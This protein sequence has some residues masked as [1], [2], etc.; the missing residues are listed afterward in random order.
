MTI[1]LPPKYSADIWSLF[2]LRQVR[3]HWGINNSYIQLR[4]CVCVCERKMCATNTALARDCF[5][6]PTSIYL[7]P[8]KG[9]IERSG[10]LKSTKLNTKIR[11][12]NWNQYMN[13]IYTYI[14]CCG[15]GWQYCENDSTLFFYIYIYILYIWQKKRRGELEQAKCFVWAT[16]VATW[17]CQEVY[18]LVAWIC[19]MASLKANS[20]KIDFSRAVPVPYLVIHTDT[21]PP[22]QPLPL[23]LSPSAPKCRQ[24]ATS[25]NPTHET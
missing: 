15:A 16:G 9:E 8:K 7:K 12:S 3:R 2:G 21:P 14:Q 11:D 1:L 5:Q 10:G 18:E 23:R 17:D 25:V 6:I 22:R 19:V 20:K 13:T 24:G 4:M